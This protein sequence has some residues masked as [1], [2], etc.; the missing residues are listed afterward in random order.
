MPVVPTR[1]ADTRPTPKP[2]HPGGSIEVPLPE[3][4]TDGT[5]DGAPSAVALS[6]AMIEP[7]R[8]GYITAHASRTPRGEVASGYALRR[9]IAA[10]FAITAASAAGLSVYSANGTELTA[11][12]LGWF[13]GASTPVTTGAPENPV[14]PQR[15]LAI[16]DSTMAGVDRT[17]AH[18]ALRG[19]IFD[20]RALSCRRLVRASCTGPRAAVPPP[21]AL[22]TLRSIPEDAYDVLV[23][24]TGYNDTMP[25]FVTDV[26]T[27]V[28]EARVKGFRRIIWL[29]QAREYR[30]DKGGAD[31]Y[32]VYEL[33]N[34]VI[35]ANAAA[36][37]FMIAPEWSSIIR[38]VPW[39]TYVDGIHLAKPGGYGAA[40]LISR[41]VAHVTGQRCPLPEVPGGP[42]EGVC[43]E[44]GSRPPID[45]PRLYGF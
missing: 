26:P 40:D 31:A 19:A 27:I 21:T 42:N 3:G 16:G 22:D 9:E 1:L 34:Q 23:M 39:W 13:T 33:H 18:S 12:L 7:D 14:P 10:Q 32:Q 25:G 41:A 38:Q 37:D 28:H 20:F 8:Q 24:M 45:I 43:P 5:Q 36:H 4:L 29:T 11:D 30:H 6:L 35:R 2:I 15:V 44:P 17:F